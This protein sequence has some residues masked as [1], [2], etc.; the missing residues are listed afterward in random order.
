MLLVEV[1]LYAAVGVAAGASLGAGLASILNGLDLSWTPPGSTNPV[2]F[3]FFLR[4]RY[5]A[6]PA[7]IV[8]GASLLA[9]LVPAVRSARMRV[10][11]ELSYE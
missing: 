6:G 10:A 11:E 2:P 3:G 9:A 8:F 4:W 1:C 7:A 5:L